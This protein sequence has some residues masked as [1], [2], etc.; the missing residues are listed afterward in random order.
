MEEK[1]RVSFVLSGGSIKGAFQ[2]GAIGEILRRGIVPD[3]LYGISVGALNG[4]FLANAAGEA[5]KK[6]NN[7]DWKKI[8]D[9]LLN[10]WKDNIKDPSAIIRKRNIFELGYQI[11]F[12][13]FKGILDTKRLFKL[14]KRT[15][16]RDNLRSSSA[17]L[18]VG[19]VDI[20][21]SEQ[22]VRDNSDENII[23]YILASTAIPV[24]MPTVR[25]G[26][27][28]PL[29]DG[30]LRDVAILKNAIKDGA[31]T[32]YCILCQPAEMAYANFNEGNLVKFAERLMAIVVDETVTNDIDVANKINQD[33][34]DLEMLRKSGQ[35]ISGDLFTRLEG[36][37]KVK[38]IVIRPDK[39][40]DIDI[41]KFDKNDI[42]RIIQMGEDKAKDVLGN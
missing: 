16:E 29:T 1:A 22:L 7:P 27:G 6:E 24:I 5:V 3:H 42:K 11:I 32:I 15:L 4:G 40:P 33:I 20:F 38:I 31:K 2:V 13:K 39:E 30:G 17:R 28:N 19:A 41:E 21:S 26:R 14:V 10:F 37:E 34:D 18:Q 12:G 23:D 36:K 25:I 8:G 9:D 35:P